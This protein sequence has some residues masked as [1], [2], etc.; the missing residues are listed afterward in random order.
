MKKLVIFDLDGTLL[1]TIADLG[2]ATNYAMEQMGFVTYP[3]DDYRFKVGN[4]ITK[5][6]ERALPA[7]RRDPATVGQAREHFLRY[8]GEHC[9]DHSAPYPGIPELLAELTARGVKV[10]VASNKYHAAT[11]RLVAHFFPNVPWAAV[12]GHRP[13]RPTKPAPAIVEA[14]LRQAGV[15]PT[16][17]LYVG[18]SGVDMVTARNASLESVGVTWGFRPEDEL[19]DNGARHIV[20]APAE[21]LTL[22]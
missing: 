3:I 21:I 5:L 22:L 19:R 18:D 13:E 8:Y 1:N 15:A 9:T 10:A 2:T 20:N 17:T 16:E 14:I 11:S 7:D 6:I 4:G 12:E